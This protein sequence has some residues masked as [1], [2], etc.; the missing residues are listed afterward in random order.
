[1]PPLAVA[2][3]HVD[4]GHTAFGQPHKVRGA[5][6]ACEFCCLPEGDAPHLKQFRC[7]GQPSVSGGVVLAR[8]G[9]SPGEKA[10]SCERGIVRG[11]FSRIGRADAID[12]WQQ[13]VGIALFTRS[14][15]HTFVRGPSPGRLAASKQR[16]RSQSGNSTSALPS[17]SI[18]PSWL[19]RVTSIVTTATPYGDSNSLPMT[20]PST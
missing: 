13:P 16:R 8:T 1:M 19:V 3:R 9:Y 4:H 7:C 18:P 12:G 6:N 14:Q 11:D 10:C 20:S 15:S 5:G 17:T 2:H